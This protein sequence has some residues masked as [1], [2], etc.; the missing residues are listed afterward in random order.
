M[1]KSPR[2]SAA[3]PSKMKRRTCATNTKPTLHPQPSQCSETKSAGSP[4]R[5]VVRRLE[6]CDIRYGLETN[7]PWLAEL[8]RRAD[9]AKRS[10]TT[11]WTRLKYRKPMTMIQAKK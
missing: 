1:R 8:V 7:D 6:S 2:H 11:T 9:A 10:S 4:K 5:Q 3:N